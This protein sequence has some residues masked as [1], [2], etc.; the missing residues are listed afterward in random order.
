MIS[1]K[2]KEL[3]IFSDGSIITNKTFIKNS[4]KTKILN[5]DYKTLTTKNSNL[6]KHA[7]K[8]FKGKQFEHVNS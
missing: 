1:I 4:N 5:K 7:L 6:K 8:C 3:V 2:K